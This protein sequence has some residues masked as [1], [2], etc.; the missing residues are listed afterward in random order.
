MAQSVN[1]STSPGSKALEPQSE[2]RDSLRGFLYI[3]VATFF[4]GFSATLGRAAFSGRLL[5]SLEIRGIN[6]VILSQ[7]RTGFSFLAL[8]LWFIARP[9]VRALRVPKRDLAKL[10]LLGLA[11]LAVSNYFYY[12]AIQRT[13][14]ATAIIVQYTA[15][16]WVLLYMVARGAERL[17]VSKIGTVLLAITGIALVIGLFRPGGIQLDMIGV[18]AALVASFSFAY[19]NVAGHYLLERHNRWIVILYA[20]FAAS[21]FWIAVNPPNKIIAAHYS[22]GAWLFLAIFSFLSMLL[23]FTLYFAGLKLLVPTKAIIASCLEPVFAILIAA[24][25]LKE[26][27]GFV[28]AIGIAMVLSAIVLAQRSSSDPRPIAGPVD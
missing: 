9:G 27:V 23:P 1:A 8:A 13:N 6:P 16:V 26:A 10:V 28:Q 12:L 7:C 22:A 5:P 19:Y 2:T 21:L 17:T 14:V 18:V 3:G 25:A 4:W 15:P 11:G 20:T 24:I